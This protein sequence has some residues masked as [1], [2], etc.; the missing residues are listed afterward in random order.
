VDNLR[1]LNLSRRFAGFA[2]SAILASLLYVI[3]VAISA[4]WDGGTTHRGLIFGLRFALFFMFAGGF[5][6]AWILMIVLWAMAVWLQLKTRWDARIYFPAVGALLVLV[7]GS[8]ASSIAPTPAWMQNQTFL[9]G[10]AIAAERQGLCL[11]ASG[12][13]FGACYRGFEQHIQRSSEG[14]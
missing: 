7:L 13:V 5:A 1:D 14:S 11:L 2:V 3:W 6:L 12:L 9:Q 10:A 8:A 4:A